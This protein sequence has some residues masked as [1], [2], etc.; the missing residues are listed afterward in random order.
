ML[1]GLTKSQ[2]EV[3]AKTKWVYPNQNNKKR[4]IKEER[5]KKRWK[6][7][8]VEWLIVIPSLWNFEKLFEPYESFSFIA[9]NHNLH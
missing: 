2:E 3:I 8:R 9:K 5:Q 4:Q 7:Q 6:T 1:G